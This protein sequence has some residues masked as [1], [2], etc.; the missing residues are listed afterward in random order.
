MCCAGTLD[1]QMSKAVCCVLVGFLALFP[2][3]ASLQVG[4]L[5]LPVLGR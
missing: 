1:F 3:V 2:P 4:A 5:P